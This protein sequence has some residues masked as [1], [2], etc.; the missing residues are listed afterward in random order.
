MS[1]SAPIA[2]DSV[3]SATITKS[4]AKPALWWQGLTLD[5]QDDWLDRIDPQG[6]APGTPRPMSVSQWNREKKR[7]RRARERWIQEIASLRRPCHC[8]T[9]RRHRRPPFPKYY[10]VNRISYE[11]W[12]EEQT[13]DDELEED[14]AL[15]RNDRKRAGI[16]FVS[17]RP[18]EY[19]PRIYGGRG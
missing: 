6:Y 13:I 16:A 17:R 11:C 15:L 1:P 2:D 5:E 3:V 14:L 8:K 7:I 19:S 10:V 18:V 12:L 9:C 4:S